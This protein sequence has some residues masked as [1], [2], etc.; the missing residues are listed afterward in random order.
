M[1][2][3]TSTHV[4]H[5]VVSPFLRGDRESG[6]RKLL[7]VLLLPDGDAVFCFL[8]KAGNNTQPLSAHQ[9]RMR[10]PHGMGHTEHSEHTEHMEHMEHSGQEGQARTGTQPGRKQGRAGAPQGAP[11]GRGSP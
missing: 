3:P 7:G 10:P 5:G 6:H 4:S 9:G 8:L 1:A 11:G 2:S